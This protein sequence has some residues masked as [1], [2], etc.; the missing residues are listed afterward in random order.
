MADRPK[1]VVKMNWNIL[2]V[3]DDREKLE[4]VSIYLRNQGYHVF[5]ASNGRE[6]LDM[7]AAN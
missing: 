2:V 3:E 5:G 4:G 1:G 6:G 7:I